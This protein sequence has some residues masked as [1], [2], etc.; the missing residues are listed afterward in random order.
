[1]TRGPAANDRAP[2]RA[3]KWSAVVVAGKPFDEEAPF[4]E[5]HL[6]RALAAHHPTL[7]V[8]PPSF[9]HT[10]LRRR[11]WGD[12]RPSVHH[13]GDNLRVLRPMTAPGANRSRWA[14]IGDRVV[15]A[16]V[17]RRAESLLPRPRVIL[18]LD[19]RRGTLPGVSRDALVYW[20]RDRLLS[21]PQ[22]KKREGF[23][24]RH[25]H[26]LEAADLVVGVTESLVVDSGASRTAC[27][28]NGC[29]YERF[30]APADAPGELTND[31]VVLGYAGAISWR[32]DGELL[33]AVA[34]ARPTW[35]IALIGT[36]RSPPPQRPNIVTFG[37]RPYRDLPGWM[38]RFDVGLV[39]YQATSFN[40]ASFPLKI[41]EYLAA[42]RPVVS[43]SLAGLKNLEPYVRR[44]DGPE[45]FVTAIEQALEHGPGPAACRDI[46][47]ANAWEDRVHRLEVEV[48]ELLFDRNA[49]RN[50]IGHPAWRLD[51][52]R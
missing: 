24:L 13:R 52:S 38:Q 36:V 5:T 20:Q 14:G 23:E 11:S 51:Q 33:A 43:T 12:L 35:T 31:G 44:A 7:V 19:P 4:A 28:P 17:R 49:G 30:A 21:K 47:R 27:I 41:Y 45:A 15:N 26:L 8:D 1:M 48:D 42:G 16:Q 39:P 6:A 2:G 50:V 29:D 18:T 40:H 9:V 3:P 34:D 37:A 22:L 32:L 25:R 10:S 46:A